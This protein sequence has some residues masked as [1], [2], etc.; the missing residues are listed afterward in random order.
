MNMPV[1]LVSEERLTEA[2]A[3]CAPGAVPALGAAYGLRSI[4]DLSMACA[5]DVYFEAGDHE[6][7]IHVSGEDYRKLILDD[8]Q[9]AEVSRHKRD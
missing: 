9:F 3:D 4:V 7:L 1:S 2:F 8:A 5:S 6:D